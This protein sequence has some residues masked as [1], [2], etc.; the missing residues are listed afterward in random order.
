MKN[1]I[2]ILAILFIFCASCTTDSSSDDSDDPTDPDTS[3]ILLKR[4]VI[5]DGDEDYTIN[6]NYDG[7][8]LIGY[9]ESD[10]FYTTYT[11]SGDLLVR[12]DAYFGSLQESYTI[13]EYDADDVLSQFTIYFT[14]E[15]T[16]LPNSASKQVVT[17]LS[18]N[19]IS[20]KSYSGNYTSQDV[21]EYETIDT[22]SN[23]NWIERRFVEDEDGES[24]ETYVFDN[25]NG[26]LKNLHQ[27]A[28]FQ[29]FGEPGEGS[30]NNPVNFNS[31]ETRLE[32][33]YN[34]NDFPVSALVYDEDETASTGT[35]LYF[36]E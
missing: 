27:A 7:N 3:S 4:K 28:I 10:G 1:T 13:L 23:G 31:G 21:F 18:S 34:S 29:L 16:G 35:I 30:T 9:D 33:T 24:I 14:G 26:I 11:Y 15:V 2:Q 32:Y 19:Q 5:Q 6:Y 20:V 25:K 22:Y 36:Y 17:Y 8:K 12:E